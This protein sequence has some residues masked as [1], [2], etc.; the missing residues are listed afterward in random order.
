MSNTVRWMIA[1]ILLLAG[2]LTALFSLF[3]L[4]FFTWEC[5]GTPNSIAYTILYIA[6]GISL[7]AGI[8]PA[9]MLVRK[10]DGKLTAIAIVLGIVFTLTGLGTFMYYTL[11]I[12]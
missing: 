5:Y 9:V 7:I 6:A 4:G 3:F 11:N 10:V 8:V 2:V 1:V 12:C